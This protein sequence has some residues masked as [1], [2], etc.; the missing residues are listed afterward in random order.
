MLGR[1]QHAIFV[2]R[3]EHQ[4]GIFDVRAPDI[5]VEDGKRHPRAFDIKLGK[6]GLGHTFA[7]HLAVE[8]SGGNTERAELIKLHLGL[9]LRMPVV[10]HTGN[11]VAGSAK[12]E[13]RGRHLKRSGSPGGA[14]LAIGRGRGVR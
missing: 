3:G 12:S 14:C 13:R 1:F 7:P 4:R 2:A 5:D 11:L 10:W 9:C 6:G 8:V